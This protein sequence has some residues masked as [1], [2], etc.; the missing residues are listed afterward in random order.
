[1]TNYSIPQPD[2]IPTDHRSVHDLLIRALGDDSPLIPHIQDRKA[3]GLKKYGTPLQVG[4]GRDARIDGFQEILDGIIYFYKGVISG[5]PAL[6]PLLK[7]LEKTA[8]KFLE[9]KDHV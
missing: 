4:N 2:P 3:F 1:M 5:D 6:Y 7:E 9:L 8:I